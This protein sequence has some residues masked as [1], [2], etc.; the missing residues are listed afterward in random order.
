MRPSDRPN[1]ARPDDFDSILL[2]IC[3][4]DRDG[5]IS[6]KEWVRLNE[7][8]DRLDQNHDGDLDLAECRSIRDVANREPFR[9]RT[10]TNT[11]GNEDSSPPR[12]HCLQARM[13]QATR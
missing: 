8:F 2:T 5:R 1:Q 10:R 7:L 11:D 12:L 6:K 9:D 4:I 3:D 13:N